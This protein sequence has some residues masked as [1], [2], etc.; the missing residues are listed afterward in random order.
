MSM[1]RGDWRG[2]VLYAWEVRRVHESMSA[3]GAGGLVGLSVCNS[4]HV[5]CVYAAD[6]LT[7]SFHCGRFG[8]RDGVSASARARCASCGRGGSRVMCLPARLLTVG[9]RE[10]RR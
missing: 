5:H 3:G 1:S 6:D 2:C 4:R 7:S 10:K 9:L 8:E